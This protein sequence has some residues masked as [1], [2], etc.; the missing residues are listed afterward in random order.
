MS[1]YFLK[2]SFTGG[3]AKSVLVDDD[4]LALRRVIS[5]FGR[6]RHL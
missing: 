2:T 4:V 5:D 6:D 3:L 1:T